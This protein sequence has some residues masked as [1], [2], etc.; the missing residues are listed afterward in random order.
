MWRE[1]QRLKGLM[2]RMGKDGGMFKAWRTWVA[3]ADQNSYLKGVA[4]RIVHSGVSRAL[5]RWLEMIAERQHLARFIKRALNSGLAR[6][7]SAWVD[8]AQQ[9]ARDR[10]QLAK[11][12]S[13]M[14]K[15]AEMRAW[16]QWLEMLE[17]RQRMQTIG[18]KMLN[19]GLTKA[20]NRCVHAVLAVLAAPPT[21]L[22][23]SRPTSKALGDRAPP[24]ARA[25]CGHRMH[26][27]PA[28]R[29]RDV[30][31]SHACNRMHSLCMQ[32]HAF[33]LHATACI[34]SARN[35]MHSLCMHRHQS[36][37]APRAGASPAHSLHLPLR[38]LHSWLAYLEERDRLRAI[39][40]RAANGAVLRAFSSWLDG[41]EQLARMRGVLARVVDGRAGRAF[42][43]WLEAFDEGCRLRKFGA[44][45]VNGSSLRAWNQWCEV[46]EE[47]RRLQTCARARAARMHARM[48]AR[49]HAHLCACVC[50]VCVMRGSRSCAFVPHAP[51]MARLYGTMA[52]LR[53]TVSGVPDLHA[54]RRA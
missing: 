33:T 47:R 9:A 34:H 19:L 18:A 23:L 40:S 8:M 50:V 20:F 51:C 54:A 48:H 49:T 25:T 35:R 30:R 7:L 45:I 17:Q 37:S 5:N 4:S 2:R 32:P 46:V 22:G 38:W 10:R 27:G 42:N 13:R 24:L 44:R 21:P 52:P 1:R 43:R 53:A 41:I 3:L 31:A 36:Q 26:A 39:M 11:F 6:G 16:N 28:P 14:L 29:S 12:G 15:I